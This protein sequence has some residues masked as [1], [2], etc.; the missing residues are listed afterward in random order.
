MNPRN[1]I[2]KALFD[3]LKVENLNQDER[4][5]R[6][7]KAIA[8]IVAIQSIYGQF[9]QE[10]PEIK[11]P[12]ADEISLDMVDSE[13]RTPLIYAALKGF[14]E[15]V[16]ALLEA[17]A[18]PNK[19]NEVS[20]VPPL[21]YA[22]DNGHTAIVTALLKAK[23]DANKLFKKSGDTP[24]I[25]AIAGGH[26][27]IVTMLLE[28]K[29]D[30]IKTGRSTPFI[31]AI[32]RGHT[33]IVPILLEAKADPNEADLTRDTPLMWAAFKGHRKQVQQLI[34][35]KANLELQNTR[36]NTALDEA[37]NNQK[38]S[39]V[40]LLLSHGAVIRHPQQLFD[41]LTKKTKDDLLY[42]ELLC[43][44]R[45]PDVLVSLKFLCE[46]LSKS[47]DRKDSDSE[48]KENMELLSKAITYYDKL[49]KLTDLYRE[50]AVSTL[51]ESIGKISL[52]VVGLF[53]DYDAPL[54]NPRVGFFKP[55]EI[56]AQIS[57][58]ERLKKEKSSDASKKPKS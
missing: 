12:P 45:D 6:A 10:S 14:T 27:A 43:D 37:V 39:T 31:V 19:S 2:V 34:E 29:A 3:V 21:A 50:Q 4:I 15:I 26:S 28:A 1:F 40:S 52:D 44:Q 55:G 58:A 18:D 5:Y 42:G 8:A 17:K 33:A 36:R 41:F 20:D 32:Q 57:E 54:Q 49:K 23:A 7:K 35:V 46:Q 53:A 24:L 9:K 47:L 25:W 30:L 16:T 22:A 51:S 38:L 56:D 11:V 13:G 48:R